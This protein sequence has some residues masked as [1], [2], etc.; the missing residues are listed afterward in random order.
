LGRENLE[1]LVGEDGFLE[2]AHPHLF[3]LRRGQ[4]EKVLVLLDLGQSG[5]GHVTLLPLGKPPA[6]TTW[7]TPAVGGRGVH[8]KRGDGGRTG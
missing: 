5:D 2:I 4:M 3:L 8:A 1:V 7:P 6:A